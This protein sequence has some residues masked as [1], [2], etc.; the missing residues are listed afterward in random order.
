VD[1]KA[2]EELLISIMNK[3]LSTLEM[4]TAHGIAPANALYKHHAHS[5]IILIV[6]PS[7][8]KETTL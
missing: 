1:V 5:P 2:S 6:N 7:P 3:C 8:K 4:I